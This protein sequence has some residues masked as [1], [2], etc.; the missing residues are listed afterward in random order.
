[1]GTLRIFLGFLALAKD[2][3]LH[4]LQLQG[5]TEGPEVV[6]FKDYFG[7]N[8]GRPAPFLKGK[9]RRETKGGN[10]AGPEKKQEGPKRKPRSESE[11]RVEGY[12]LRIVLRMNVN[13]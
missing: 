4:G 11:S 8:Q 6:F 9:Q 12:K 7:Y 13:G 3:W 2:P 10:R 5:V 1:M